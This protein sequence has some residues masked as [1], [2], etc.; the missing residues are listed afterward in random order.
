MRE[1]GY[2]YS[3]FDER[4]L[5]ASTSK[6]GK[7]EVYLVGL[8]RF[9]A[10]KLERN[11]DIGLFSAL[12]RVRRRKTDDPP[13]YLGPIPKNTIPPDRAFDQI[14]TW[15]RKL[16]GQT[17]FPTTTRCIGWVDSLPDWLEIGVPEEDVDKFNEVWD[18]RPEVLRGIVCMW[19]GAWLS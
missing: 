1:R 19:M 11:G 13:V 3:G 18:R 4:S 14:T 12:D 9:N 17:T 8:S 16:P 2:E 10:P 6:N 5:V 7:A 15:A